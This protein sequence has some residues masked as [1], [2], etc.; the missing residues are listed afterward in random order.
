MRLRRAG[1][2]GFPRPFDD[3]F[4]DR[5]LYSR[6]A[7]LID[8][9]LSI[10]AELLEIVCRMQTDKP[11]IPLLKEQRD[12]FGTHPKHLNGGVLVHLSGVM[13]IAH[14]WYVEGLRVADGWVGYGTTIHHLDMRGPI[15]IGPPLE[16]MVR[17]TRRRI[18]PKVR[19]VRYDLVYKQK[20]RVV[21]HGDQSAIWRKMEVTKGPRRNMGPRK[22]R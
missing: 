12:P 22:N 10:D 5:N 21:Y 18:R 1:M 20:D 2:S 14:S 4:L 13:G 17:A 3:E 9:I 6:P 11:G 7:I 19:I 15:E 8:E 16:L